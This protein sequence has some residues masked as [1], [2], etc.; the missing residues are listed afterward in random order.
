[1]EQ[2]YGLAA[3]VAW[4]PWLAYGL[5]IAAT[6]FRLYRFQTP[7]YLA[8]V[9][10]GGAVG[11]SLGHAANMLWPVMPPPGAEA[12]DPYLSAFW[13]ALLTAAAE[14]A[15]PVRRSEFAKPW[16]RRAALA[17]E[18]GLALLLF[19]APVW[20]PELA[21]W[22]SS[23]LVVYFLLAS[24]L[25]LSA[26][27][28]RTRVRQLTT[29]AA[30]LGAQSAQAA[31]AGMPALRE[32]N[33]Q[34]HRRLAIWAVL[35]TILV[36][37]L[38]CASTAPG[39]N[40]GDSLV[41][42]QAEQI[43]ERAQ[44]LAQPGPQQ[45]AGFQL[46]QEAACLK[47]IRQIP[48]LWWRLHCAVAETEFGLNPYATRRGYFLYTYLSPVDDSPQ[49]YAIWV[50]SD[51]NPA[52]PTPTPLVVWLHGWTGFQPW[53]GLWIPPGLWTNR[54][55]V[56]APQARGSLDYTGIQAHEVWAALAD[57]RARYSVDPDRIYLAGHSMG[58]TGAWY[59]ATQ[60]PNLIAAIAPSSANLSPWAWGYKTPTGDPV[61]DALIVR[62]Q[63]NEASIG[64]ADRLIRMP[65]LASHSND[66]PVVP[67][68][69]SRLMVAAIRAARV[70]AG[71]PADSPDQCYLEAD[72]QSLGHGEAVSPA[73]R[74]NWLL[75]HRRTDPA[76]SAT[77][78]AVGNRDHPH[79]PDPA[80]PRHALTVPAYGPIAR[81]FDEPFVLIVP[82]R[83]QEWLTHEPTD[84]RQRCLREIARETEAFQ[85][86]WQDRNQHPPRVLAASAYLALDPARTRDWHPILLGGPDVNLATATLL[87]GDG[88][89]AAYRVP[90]GIDIH[91]DSLA[92]AGVRATRPAVLYAIVPPADDPIG[93]GDRGGDPDVHARPFAVVIAASS[94]EGYF[95]CL[96][97]FGSL[98]SSY[99]LHHRI[100]FDYALADAQ[101]FDDP[102]LILACGFYT[103]DGRLAPDD[104]TRA[105]TG[106]LSAR[107]LESGTVWPLLP[108]PP[109]ALFPGLA[110]PPAPGPIALWRTLPTRVHS[111]E[112]L[113]FD[114]HA[115]GQPLA[116]G[117]DPADGFRGARTVRRGIAFSAMGPVDG[118]GCVEYTLP[119]G[120][121]RLTGR[122]GPDFTVYPPLHFAA[123]AALHLPPTAQTEQAVE[124]FRVRVDGKEIW[125]SA[126]LTA[127]S[128]EPAPAAW[129]VL[130]YSLDL[131][132]PAGH[133]LTLEAFPLRGHPWDLP[134]CVWADL[135]LTPR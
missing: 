115:L 32:Q 69:N 8:L 43:V 68:E 42:L 46:E 34:T 49:S 55:I 91:E 44:V 45:A 16:Q 33:S 77:A 39:E 124:G 135:Q 79:I 24:L 37:A 4:H 17:Q 15:R 113:T 3:L 122:V 65:F 130:E 25:R 88:P 64:G 134:P 132:L 97:R 36:A 109:D 127:P 52:S 105:F 2:V 82:D 5:V 47:A 95:Q 56:I 57:V 27:L 20:R 129:R 59:L 31:Q 116:L 106:S 18:V 89:L 6:L 99:A 30:A 7:A 38:W 98:L 35:L 40:L 78:A 60:R 133:T 131:D 85:Q 114:A 9:A 110:A 71:L 104:P 72:G 86:F 29:G 81:A 12:L 93:A 119:P 28:R 54:A 84:D 74:L 21:G 120:R 53:V 23:L 121:W 96:R 13:F 58:G 112:P 128:G 100:W 22:L 94:P 92:V 76:Q 126:P 87:E 117:G 107:I 62:L 101:S 14:V 111:D 103:P 70:Q 125:L 51:Y 48:I 19:L 63:K 90:A 80:E 118:P 26:W 108:P 102:R 61:R 1:M 66:D 75:M 67:V 50:P 73:A 41:A 10:V 123:L 83:C 11:L